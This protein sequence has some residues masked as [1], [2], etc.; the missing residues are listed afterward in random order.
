MC[1]RSTLRSV[2]GP[3]GSATGLCRSGTN[4]RGPSPTLAREEFDE[5]PPPHLGFS[6]RWFLGLFD[7][8][9][10]LVGVAVVVSDLG[11]AGVWHIALYLVAT[12]LHGSGLAR[13]MLHSLLRWAR[14]AGGRWMRLGVVKG[15]LRAER[16]WAREGFVPLRVREGVDTGGRLNDVQVRMKPLLDGDLVEHYLERVP[17]DRPDSTLP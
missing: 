14:E 2:S 4:G 7:R 16:F 13:E 17:R 12:P 8:Q 15:N 1:S 5:S 6:R 3:R 9:D 11:A 10:A